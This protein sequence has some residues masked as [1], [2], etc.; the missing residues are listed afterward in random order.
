MC[1]PHI[2]EDTERLSYGVCS[3]SSSTLL[4]TNSIKNEEYDKVKKL[5]K[6][7][8]KIVQAPSMK[9]LNDMLIFKFPDIIVT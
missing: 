4:H 7:V 6:R 3:E 8:N 9:Y 1:F 2:D 5:L